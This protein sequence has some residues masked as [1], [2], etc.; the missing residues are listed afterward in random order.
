MLVAG[1]GLSLQP[2]MRIALAAPPL[3][4]ERTRARIDAAR[5]DLAAA[6]ARAPWL[7]LAIVA[8]AVLRHAIFFSNVTIRNHYNLQT[9]GYDLGIE[10]NLVWNAAHWNGPLFK[11][12]VQMGGP[13]ATHIGLHQ[14]YISYLIGIPY[15]LVPRPETLL[16]LQSLL[17]GAAALPL[18]AYA[19]RHLGAW[20]ACLSRC[21][22]SST[23]P[24]TARTC[25]TFITCRSRRSSCG[26]RWRCWTRAAIAGRRSRS[27]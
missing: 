19:R 17:I 16:V 14:T 7:P 11:T 6:L 18:Y 8:V 10:N 3:L 9:A 13:V 2:L 5:A 24:F 15:R 23:R 1:F 21:S 4:P 12:S 27:C 22:V 25:T 20:T 26:R